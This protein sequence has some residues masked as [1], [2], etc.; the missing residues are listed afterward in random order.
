MVKCIVSG[1]GNLS[2]VFVG[3]QLV[4]SFFPFFV[5]PFLMNWISMFFFFFFF[6]TGL[7]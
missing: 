2:D 5:T 6:F 4:W 7:V 3:W 1:S